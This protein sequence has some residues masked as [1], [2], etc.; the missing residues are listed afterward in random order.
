LSQQPL[1]AS[2]PFSLNSS[3]YV[4]P[5]F[6]PIFCFVNEQSQYYRNEDDETDGDDYV[7]DSEDDEE[8]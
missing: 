2:F 1:T 8:E 5:K 6:D 4:L 3:S 7:R